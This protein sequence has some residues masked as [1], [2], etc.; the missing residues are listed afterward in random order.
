MSNVASP[1]MHWGAAGNAVLVMMS[2]RLRSALHLNGQ[3][4]REA[5]ASSD[6]DPMAARIGSDE[7]VAVLDNL[8]RQ[9]DARGVARRLLELLK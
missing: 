1:E 4:G 3:L 7:F 5:D 8:R 6:D 2:D 9:N